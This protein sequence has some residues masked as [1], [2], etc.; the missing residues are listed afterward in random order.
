M[1]RAAAAPCQETRRAN[2]S[3]VRLAMSSG[4]IAAQGQS[5]D[6]LATPERRQ[7]RHAPQTALSM[8][9]STFSNQR[10]TIG[11]QSRSHPGA[12]RTCQSCRG[13]VVDRCSTTLDQHTASATNTPLQARCL[14]PGHGAAFAIVGRAVFATLRLIADLLGCLCVP[15]LTQGRARHVS[16]TQSTGAATAAMG[17]LM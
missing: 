9:Y 5:A 14:I 13:C 1:A 2:M 10:L 15:H 4:P 3:A 12:A 11:E 16:P 7:T 6:S 17:R 8:G